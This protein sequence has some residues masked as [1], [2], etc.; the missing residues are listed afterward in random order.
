MASCERNEME[1]WVP[2]RRGWRR[3]RSL[4]PYERENRPT[5]AGNFSNEKNLTLRRLPQVF[6]RIEVERI[7]VGG[8]PRPKNFYAV[9]ISPNSGAG[10]ISA[11]SGRRRAR[12]V[13]DFARRAARTNRSTAPTAR[14]RQLLRMIGGPKPR[15]DLQPRFFSCNTR[16]R[17]NTLDFKRA[18]WL[19]GGF[20]R[21]PMS[22]LKS[23]DR[24]VH[25][26]GAPA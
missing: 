17:G 4:Y 23:F 9:R 12:P 14:P 16:R 8:V 25:A 26:V 11:L 22:R 5:E 18:Q 13:R 6:I 10:A 21:R 7:G 20:V 15:A 24:L 1:R 19:A 2:V 3:T